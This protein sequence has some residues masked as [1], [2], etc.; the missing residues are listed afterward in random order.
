[1]AKALGNEKITLGKED[2]EV[3]KFKAA[4]GG[5]YRVAIDAKKS[6][7]KPGKTSGTTTLELHASISKGEHK[8]IS[9][10]DNIGSS[11]TWKIGQLLSA[12]G[13]KK[14]TE[15]TLAKLLKMLID[16]GELRALLRAVKFEGK[17]RN[18]VVQWLPLKNDSAGDDD[19]GTDDSDDDDDDAGTDDDDDAG[20]TTTTTMMTS[21]PG[22]MTTMTTMTTRRTRT[23]TTT[24][25]TRRRRRR[26][27]RA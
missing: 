18:E 21:R 22:R 19:E 2:F 15:I 1:M 8:K 9:F 10:I 27:R 11:V 5:T 24:T 17:D 3:K 16:A 14:T 26:R 25:T 20:T 4:P 12:L 6:K 7:L 13:K 23:M